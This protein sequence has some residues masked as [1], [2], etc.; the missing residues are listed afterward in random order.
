[1]MKRLLPLLAV[2]AMFA[3][4]PAAMA[5]HC[6]RCKIRSLPHMEPPSCVSA[7]NFGFVSCIE[8]FENDTCIVQTACGNHAVEPAE[9]LASEFTVASVER[10]DDAQPAPNTALVASLRTTR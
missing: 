4:A 7:I 1:M 10:L 8:D 6:L 3:A 5:N 2:V 9:P